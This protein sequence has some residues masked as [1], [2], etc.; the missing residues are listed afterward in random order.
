MT[1]DLYRDLAEAVEILGADV[2]SMVSRPA[3]KLASKYEEEFMGRPYEDLEP[4]Q[5]PGTLEAFLSIE[6]DLSLQEISGDDKE[7]QAVLEDFSELEEAGLVETTGRRAGKKYFYGEKAHTVLKLVDSLEDILDQGY[8]NVYENFSRD[9]KE[10]GAEPVKGKKVKANG[11][12]EKNPESAEKLEEIREARNGGN[13]RDDLSDRFDL[14]DGTGEGYTRESL[15][16]IGPGILG[17]EDLEE[18]LESSEPVTI[19]TD[20][21]ERVKA[22]EVVESGGGDPWINDSEDGPYFA[23]EGVETGDIMVYSPEELLDSG[24][25]D[26]VKPLAV[27][28]PQE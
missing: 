1:N 4:L 8:T 17:E 26:T 9:L 25:I 11:S 14:E 24:S 5:N 28:E 6:P 3:R 21:E 22:A 27:L 13:P 23:G 2:E 20:L 16:E 12:G 10:T 15:E 7:Y 18:I 19:D